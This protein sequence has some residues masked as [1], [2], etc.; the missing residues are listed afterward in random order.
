MGRLHKS[1]ASFNEKLRY[2]ID[3][4]FQ[5]GFTLQLFIASLLVM[6]VLLLFVMVAEVFHM[7]PSPD[8]DVDD[9]GQF[10]PSVRFWWVLTHT[11]DTYWIE[12][13]LPEQIISILLTLFNILVFASVVGLVGSKIQERLENMRRG[14]SRAIEDGHY[15]IIGWSEKVIPIIRELCAGLESGKRIFAIL[16][17]RPID[18]I[19][20]AIKKS[21]GRKRNQRFVIRQGSGTDVND[22]LLVSIPTSRAVIILR[23]QSIREDGDSH[24]V[25][26]IMAIEHLINSSEDIETIPYVVAEIERAETAVLAHAAANGMPLSLVQPSDYLGKIILQTARQSGLVQIYDEILEHSRSEVHTAP[27]SNFPGIAG[28]PWERVVFS[29]PDAIPIGVMRGNTPMMVPNAADP[30][31]AVQPGDTLY[32]IARDNDSLATGG[33]EQIPAIEPPLHG[34]AEGEIIANLL[35][36][37]FNEKALPLMNE[38]NCYARSLSRTFCLTVFTPSQTVRSMLERI[39]FDSLEIELINDD[40]V[41]PGALERIDPAAF[42]TIIILSEASPGESWEDADTRVIMTL[43]LLRSMRKKA[44]ESGKVFPAFHQIVGEI[45]HASNK[46]LT[47]STRTVRDVIISQTLVSKMIAQICRDPLIEAALMDFFD[48]QGA[49]IYLKPVGLYTGQI[50]EVSFGELLAASIRR[51]E[52]AIGV[53]ATNEEYPSVY[54]IALNPKKSERFQITPWTRIV[55]LAERED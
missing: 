7:Q 22:L 34:T 31:F 51:G 15:V 55:V 16:T 19:E 23:Q 32:F 49:E 48:E 4:F 47:E 39:E 21:M 35:L 38:Y 2:R 1:A 20:R 29:F 28:K 26:S 27:V 11:L 6:T 37:G 50:S 9:T 12:K 17:E 43:L 36:I 54:D 14:T 30:S 18:E 25:K 33:E 42:D 41:Q 3:R 13:N 10:W 45:L 53:D 52:V 40:Y 46:E 5:S 44:E 24:V 8:F